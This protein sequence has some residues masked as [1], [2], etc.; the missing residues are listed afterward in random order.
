MSLEQIISAARRAQLQLKSDGHALEANS[1]QR[2]IVSRASSLST[3]KS[4]TKDLRRYRDLLKRAADEMRGCAD[5]TVIV[6][7]IDAEISGAAK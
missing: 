3:N 5:F 4:L 1:V 6:A 7:A 2:L